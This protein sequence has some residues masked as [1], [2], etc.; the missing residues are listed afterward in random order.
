MSTHDSIYDE[1]HDFHNR[2]IAHLTNI[3]MNG[4]KSQKGGI[5]K[6]IL[7]DL[8]K[9]TASVEPQIKKFNRR[10]TNGKTKEE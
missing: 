8:K 9:V 5:Y 10:C 4:S 7:K 2:L 6:S 1:L 3:E